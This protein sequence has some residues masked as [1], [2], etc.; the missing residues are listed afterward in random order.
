MKKLQLLLFALVLVLYLSSCATTV[1]TFSERDYKYNLRNYKTYA[2][3]APGD[4]S[5]NSPRPEKL[6]GEFIMQSANT[7]LKKKGMVIDTL[8]PDAIFVYETYIED[9]VKYSQSP[10][11]SVGVGF[12]GPGYYVGG[13]VPVTGGEVY[14]T[15]YTE[16]SLV[17]DMY[18]ARTGN[19]I[20]RGGAVS[21]LAVTTNMQETIQ[22][23]MNYIFQRLPV[24]HR[25]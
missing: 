14:S 11:V 9:K 10:T 8:R 15:T 19:R 23:A 12:A 2:W 24:K 22:T 1:E 6:F 7:E 4:T 5:F 21:A 13:A 16:G 25:D 18:D 17:V 20:W 3:L